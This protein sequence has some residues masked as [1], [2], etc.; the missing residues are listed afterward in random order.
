MSRIK[1]ILISAILL[2]I[3]FIALFTVALDFS[4]FFGLY[5]FYNLYP[6]YIINRI[7]VILTAALVWLAGKDSL[8]RADNRLMQLVFALMCIAEAFFLLYIPVAAVTVFAVC[9]NFLIFRHGKGL[10]PKL[11]ATALKQKIKLVLYAVVFSTPIIITLVLLPDFTKPS[12]LARTVISYWTILSISVWVAAANDMLALFPRLN[13][14]MIAIGMLLFYF[15]D[16]CVGLDVILP[17]GTIWLLAN[18]LIWVFFTP[19]IT[20]LA[21]SC[22]KYDTRSFK[23]R[24]LRYKKT[25]SV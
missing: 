4:R 15:C 22:Y 3:A 18:S 13:S 23:V 17:K 20:L 8:S 2:S 25:G 5:S 1:R 7:N 16:I 21:L 12:P 24:S 9:Q 11:L 10:I 19:A 14:K 6:S